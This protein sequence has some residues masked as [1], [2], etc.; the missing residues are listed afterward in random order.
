MSR[1]HATP[2][3]AGHDGSAYFTRHASRHARRFPLRTPIALPRH[4]TLRSRPFRP[5]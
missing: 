3:I 5:D 1:V 4:V 2:V